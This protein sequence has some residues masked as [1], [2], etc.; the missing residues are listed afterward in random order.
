MTQVGDIQEAAYRFII[1]DMKAMYIYKKTA[2]VRRKKAAEA[3]AA[4]AAEESRKAKGKRKAKGSA[5]AAAAAAINETTVVEAA[6]FPSFENMDT[7]GYAAVQ[8]PLE[9]LNIVYPQQ[10]LI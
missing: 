6:D 9:A 10:S 4:T 1:N 7:I 2:M 3:T 8:K 5:T